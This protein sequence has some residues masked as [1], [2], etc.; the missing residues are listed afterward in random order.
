M[1]AAVAVGR[2]GAGRRS[3]QSRCP[4]LPAFLCPR[5][6]GSPGPLFLV[7]RGGGVGARRALAPPSRRDSVVVVMAIRVAERSRGRASIVGPCWVALLYGTSRTGARSGSSAGFH[8]GGDLERGCAGGAEGPRLLVQGASGGG[9]GAQ[10]L[11]PVDRPS[12]V[13]P[14]G[15]ES[16]ERVR[17]VLLRGPECAGPSACGC[18][19]LAVVG[20]LVAEPSLGRR[21][22]LRDP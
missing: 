20:A 1:V 4:G 19:R 13:R 14:G 3:S 5:R 7:G 18:R 22:M 12:S 8:L 21:G 6:G 15:G 11:R 16:G 9:A 17:P 10:A 2:S